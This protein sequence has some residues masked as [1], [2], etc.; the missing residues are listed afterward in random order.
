MYAELMPMTGAVDGPPVA[1]QAQGENGAVVKSVVGYRRKPER[2]NNSDD[3]RAAPPSFWQLSLTKK[4][5]TLQQRT[6]AS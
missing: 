4:P 5:T 2:P 6:R 3:A 1:R